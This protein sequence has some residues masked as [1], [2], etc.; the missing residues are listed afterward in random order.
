M[1]DIKK[2]MATSATLAGLIRRSE[3]WLLD[4]AE[5]DLSSETYKPI[6]IDIDVSDASEALNDALNDWAASLGSDLQFVTEVVPARYNGRDVGPE[7]G[8]PVEDV[9]IGMYAAV[10]KANRRPIPVIGIQL[11]CY[12]PDV[13]PEE[14][15]AGVISRA[16]ARAVVH[17]LRHIAQYEARARA[18]KISLAASKKRFELEKGYIMSADE[19]DRPS[20]IEIDAHAVQASLEVYEELGRDVILTFLKTSE[21]PDNATKKQGIFSLKKYV[22]DDTDP[23]VLRQFLRRVIKHLKK[24]IVES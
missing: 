4:N 23:R 14:A 18:Q 11:A 17:E 1:D 10:G 7:S 6:D 5:D 3:F 2:L 22:A 12:E 15:D 20:P 24:L 16:I 21:F 8:R 9:L 19:D 13:D